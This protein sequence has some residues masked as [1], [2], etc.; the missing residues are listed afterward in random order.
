MV[1]VSSFMLVW[2][3]K[4]HPPK[5]EEMYVNQVAAR[6]QAEQNEKAQEE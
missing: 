6:E 5:S 2:N 1:L 4:V 3:L